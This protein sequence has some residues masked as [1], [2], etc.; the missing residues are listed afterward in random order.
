MKKLMKEIQKN[1]YRIDYIDK[2]VSDMKTKVY[3]I[4][5]IEKQI[6]QVDIE[7]RPLEKEFKKLK[8]EIAKNNELSQQDRDKLLQELIFKNRLLER[9]EQERQVLYNKLKE[10][11][12]TYYRHCWRRRRGSLPSHEAGPGRKGSGR[13]NYRHD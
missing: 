13:I 5:G 1:K 8:D 6:E 2:S 12:K 3:R 10:L 9:K 11:E 7:T 4:S